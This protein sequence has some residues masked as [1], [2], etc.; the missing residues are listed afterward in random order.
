MKKTFFGAVALSLF[1]ALALPSVASA[2]NVGSIGSCRN[3]QSQGAAGVVSC[4]VGFFDYFIYLVVALSVVYTVV[5]AFRMM[6][7]E[8][9]EE[10]KKTVYYGII[11][12]FVMMSIWGFVNILNRTF[13]LNINANQVNQVRLIP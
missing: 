1:V 7:E 4:L 8:K 3:L 11:A 5:G 10:G 2:Q 6:G 12:L 13:G 9:R